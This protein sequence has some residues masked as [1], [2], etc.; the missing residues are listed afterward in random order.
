[1]NTSYELSMSGT[2]CTVAYLAQCFDAGHHFN[3]GQLFQ[4]SVQSSKRRVKD[5]GRSGI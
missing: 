2:R 3:V 1:M 5:T 4:D